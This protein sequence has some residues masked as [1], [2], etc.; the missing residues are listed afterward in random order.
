MTDL[1]TGVIQTW[2]L[3]SIAS[4]GRSSEE[5]TQTCPLS[6]IQWILTGLFTSVIPIWDLL[7]IHSLTTNTMTTIFSLCIFYKNCIIF[8]SNLKKESA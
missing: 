4:T 3:S 6:P 7:S 2:G 1:C 5:A 8:A